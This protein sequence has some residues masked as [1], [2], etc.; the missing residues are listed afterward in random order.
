[1]IHPQQF[2]PLTEKGEKIIAELFARTMVELASAGI[3][4][5]TSEQRGADNFT[6]ARQSP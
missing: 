5:A 6:I 3:P 4:G 1:M 2:G